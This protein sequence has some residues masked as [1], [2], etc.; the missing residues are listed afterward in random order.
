MKKI[1][2]L[3]LL[4]FLMFSC[5]EQKTF[6]NSKNEEFIAKPY[7]W[8]NEESQKI[9]TVVYEI[10]AGNAILSILFSETIIAPLYL[11]GWEI[12]EPVRL[13]NKNETFD[14][15]YINLFFLILIGFIIIIFIFKYTKS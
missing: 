11:T 12:Y 7:G 3:F 8:A 13:K 10:N 6:T 1:L 15:N 4:S 9:D 2:F 5:A 14:S